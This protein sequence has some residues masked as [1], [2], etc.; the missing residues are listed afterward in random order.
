M[1]QSYGAHAQAFIAELENIAAAFDAG[2][3]DFPK[4]LSKQKARDVRDA[5]QAIRMFVLIERTRFSSS[6]PCR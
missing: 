4:D 1:L 5:I 6:F 3:T 2:E